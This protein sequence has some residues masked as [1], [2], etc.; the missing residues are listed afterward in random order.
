VQQLNSEVLR[1][2]LSYD[3]QTGAFTRAAD[4]RRGRAKKGDVAG[5]IEKTGYRAAHVDG[6]K[7]LEHRLAWL[8]MTGA[9]PAGQIDH[10]NGVRTDNRWANLREA[11]NG[12]N[13][14][15][16]KKAKAHNLVG[17]LGVSRSKKRFKAEIRLNGARMH[18]GTYDTP[19]L[20]HQ[21]YIA[22]KEAIHPRWQK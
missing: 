1:H 9:W 4:S 7:Y 3:P 12:E 14:Q 21:A 8:Y 10:I 16:L 11:T 20:A 6:K 19:E 22:R 5:S 15:N 2:F 18:I 17:L 13:Q